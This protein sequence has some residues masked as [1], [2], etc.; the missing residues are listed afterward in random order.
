MINGNN[1]IRKEKERVNVEQALNTNAN[2]YTVILE[3]AVR[4]RKIKFERDKKD[5]KDEKLNFYP[6]KPISQALQDIIDEHIDD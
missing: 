2:M 5:V 6:Y 1:M 4:A 3:A